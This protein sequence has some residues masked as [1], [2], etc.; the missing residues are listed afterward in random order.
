[1]IMTN[2]RKGKHLMDKR[3][4]IVPVLAAAAVMACDSAPNTPYNWNH[5]Q[6]RVVYNAVQSDLK[7]IAQDFADGNSNNL[8]NI[9][10]CNLHHDGYNGTTI[11][12]PGP[13]SADYAIAMTDYENAGDA[14]CDHDDL[15]DGQKF[16][17]EGNAEMK[18]IHLPL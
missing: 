5:G 12:P 18:L 8:F 14:F 11:L 1:M 9:A 2:M 6:G 15:L 13:S 17:N 4:I 10:G 7:G 16:L 3:I